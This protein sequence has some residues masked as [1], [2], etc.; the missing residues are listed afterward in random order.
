MYLHLWT[1][2]NCV[3]RSLNAVLSQ[4]LVFATGSGFVGLKY[5]FL[6]ED[7]VPQDATISHVAATKH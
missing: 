6:R 1:D 2:K 3:D 5:E 7:F 4:K